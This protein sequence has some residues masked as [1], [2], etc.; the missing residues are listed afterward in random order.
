MPLPIDLG[1]PVIVVAPGKW[2]YKWV[3]WVVSIELSP[4]DYMGFWESAGYSDSADIP[5]YEVP[6]GVPVPST[7]SESP[8]GP[9]TSIIS[10]AQVEMTNV[11]EFELVSTI[12]LVFAGLFISGYKKR[13]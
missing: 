3:K 1:Y 5:A 7:G 12:I 6:L 9:E 13:A 2:G 10:T 4:T 11:P 8:M